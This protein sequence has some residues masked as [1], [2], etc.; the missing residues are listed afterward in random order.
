MART[1]RLDPSIVDPDLT[2]IV[3]KVRQ[4]MADLGHPIDVV[5]SRR[6]ADEQQRL[7]E[8][9]RE[10][11]GRVVTNADGTITISRH[12]TG[13]AA[14]L[15]FVKDG[16]RTFVG[17]WDLLGKIAKEEGLEWGGDWDTPRDRPHVELER[18]DWPVSQRTETTPPRQPPALSS[19]N[20]PRS[21][22]PN[23][24]RGRGSMWMPL[25]AR[26]TN[27]LAGRGSPATATPA[28]VMPP[29]VVADVAV[30]PPATESLTAGNIDVTRRPRVS[31]P[32]GSIS[33]VRSISINEDG[34]EI[35]IPTVVNG[36]VVSDE[37]A[38][39]EYHGTGKHLGTFNSV[40]DANAAA[41]R[42]HESEA[43]KL[44]VAP[45]GFD[46][47]ALDT[48]VRV[49]AAGQ[50]AHG[51]FDFSTIDDESSADRTVDP[52]TMSDLER[53]AAGLPPKGS[54]S[55]SMLARGVDAALT[56][57]V[58]DEQARAWS[59][60][61]A[62]Q[63]GP[64]APLARGGFLR[65]IRD[66]GAALADLP[67]LIV[68]QPIATVRG[69][70]GGAVE[71]ASTF[72]S[73][74][75]IAMTAAGPVG[76]AAR[77]PLQAALRSLPEL[78]R[79]IVA[80]RVSGNLDELNRLRAEYNAARETAGKAGAIA[81]VVRA[82]EIG[83]SGA[84][85]ARGV[86]RLATAE[87]LPE[88]GAGL[89][90]LG[91]GALGVK[92]SPAV[93]T[94][95]PAVGLHAGD[96]GPARGYAVTPEGAAVSAG[97]DIPMR[98]QPDGSFV[99]AVPG[100]Y[101]RRDVRGY[102]PPGPDFVGPE[103]GPAG[104]LESMA[105]VAAGGR[106]TSRQ[107][108]AA[109]SY[110]K[111]QRPA[112]VAREFE[113][114]KEVGRQYSGDPNAVDVPLM[115]LSDDEAREMRRMLTEMETFP[116]QKHTFNET[117]G[118]G[119]GFEIVGGAA[120]A[121][122]YSDIVGGVYR[123]PP[124]RAAVTEAIRAALENKHSALGQRAR[125]VARL[126][127]QGDPT[128][129]E[130]L[131]PP[132][133]G[134]EPRRLADEADEVAAGTR[135]RERDFDFSPLD[136]ATAGGGGTS[137]EDETAAFDAFSSAVDDLS[138]AGG[139]HEPGEAGFGRAGLITRI[140]TGA[141][142]ATYGA[143]TGE[144]TEDRIQRGLTYGVAGFLAPSLLPRG[145]G[146]LRIATGRL[147]T[148][149]VP[150]TQAQTGAGAPRLIVGAAG[151]PRR[152][153]LAGLDPFFN[154]FPEELK[155]GVKRTI[156]EHGGYDAQRR[157]TIPLADVDRL[158]QAVTLD[159]TQRLRPGT[160]LNAEATH[161]YVNAVA[162][163]QAKLNDVSARIARGANTEIDLL[164]FHKLKA[165]HETAVASIMGARSEA[166]RALGTYNMLARVL[167]TG[168]LNLVRETARTMGEDAARLAAQ[169]AQLPTDPI[170]RY[171]FLQQQAMAGSSIG[172]KLRSYYYSSILSGVKTHERNALGNLAN[173]LVNLAL[174]PGAAAVDV[175]RATVTRTPREI[176]LGELPHQA[177][178]AVIGIQRGLKEFV[179]TMRYGVSRGVLTGAVDAASAGTKFDLPH[180]EFGSG[181]AN[182]FN[183][184]GRLLNA[185]DQ[186]FRPIARDMELYGAAYAQARREGLRGDALLDRMAAIKTGTDE[187]STRI[188]AQADAFAARSVFQEKS[189]ALTQF[190]QAGVKRFPAFSFVVPFIRTPANIFRQGLEFSPAGA[191]MKAARQGGRAGSQ[192]QA[193]VAVGSML[194]APLAYLAATGR[195]SGSGPRDPIE[196]ARLMESG[197]RPN[198][199]LI[200][201]RWVSFSLFQPI[202]VPAAIMAN[203]FETW[204]ERGADQ[205]SAADLAGQAVGRA[206]RSALDQSYL[207]GLYDALA[208]IDDPDRY[209]QAAVGRFGHS[210]TPFAGAQR[211]V[212]AAVDPVVRAP[213][214]IGQRIASNVPGLSTRVP[215]RVT[216]FG[217]DVTRPG[218]PIQRV[219]DPF[220]VSPVVR[221]PVA[222]ELARL[223]VR[224]GLPTADVG[225]PKGHELS[226]D[227]ALTAKRGKGRAIYTVLE[228]VIAAP[229]YARLADADKI[230]LLERAIERARRAGGRP[231]RDQYIRDALLRRMQR[232]K[233]STA[234]A[235]PL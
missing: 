187:V 179:F 77:R 54:D 173:G 124:T 198:S 79:A 163:L 114:R 197:W 205:K 11:P 140:G 13:E 94:R 225:L 18:R 1:D 119:G 90:E 112:V 161:A 78:E 183:W 130:P 55:R 146:S 91:F 104:R 136:E 193:R 214:T 129:S 218:G 47:S 224:L 36:R 7:Y 24:D 52:D 171:R 125:E 105:A 58:S 144:D 226:G 57:L 84:L 185:T 151:R 9:G 188:R 233:G 199:I 189:G 68:R 95:L 192:A 45:A 2:L 61:I 38:I 113:G 221:D 115:N 178:G 14:D 111:G 62:G 156:E 200:G 157:G 126:R 37:E 32:D 153:P 162:S 12:Q 108:E 141:A 232:G 170:A 234:Q 87:S 142:G 21:V 109:E 85:A 227:L 49:S 138:A 211:S 231:S 41:K 167:E 223:G 8:Q 28:P 25:L 17:P 230:D 201:D 203:A 93:P 175:V 33:T 22:A 122:V 202:S 118:R 168:D 107:A 229:E 3:A 207:S 220:N 20:A 6:S 215:P 116:F 134:D 128:I 70:L 145:G 228:R 219:A 82:G 35:L 73:P 30:G 160:A 191:V 165:Q 217:E 103:A 210:M 71:G 204:R 127:L 131:L 180:R 176:F 40:T 48:P 208:A 150:N 64:V 5:S 182:P 121:P 137:L 46:F 96:L 133:A 81:Q 76:R 67:R 101:A 34:R 16:K 27:A 80:V 42:L 110:V 149:T 184:P 88:A 43:A 74:F 194:L 164:E 69:A 39:R 181:G 83:A 174:T 172:E 212:T 147:L 135:P 31:N 63:G 89:A 143:A 50:P 117:F 132:S 120:G 72:T 60:S 29:P 66:T 65:T 106:Q 186:F 15:A 222:D 190:L 98:R 148:R 44:D 169:L 216:R 23:E 139:P 100:E 19:S 86:E 123:T 51:R 213:E 209:M 155:A 97:A 75:D 206:L 10:R 99:R 102:L 196:R 166:G 92:T 159:L 177:A 53:L 4:R 59:G 26:I 158:S 152:D 235:Q 154:K 195:I 56:P